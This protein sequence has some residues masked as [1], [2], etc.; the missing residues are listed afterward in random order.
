MGKKKSKKSSNNKGRS[1]SDQKTSSLIEEIGHLVEAKSL[2]ETKQEKT[3]RNLCSK[4]EKLE[5]L[6]TCEIYNSY[7]ESL[8]DDYCEELEEW[9]GEGFSDVVEIKVSHKGGKGIFAKQDIPVNTPI[10]KIS[11]SKMISCNFGEVFE[12]RRDFVEMLM[13][14]PV[15][16]VWFYSI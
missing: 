10:F 16:R 5:S 9:L 12:L 4:I 2:W 11:K 7:Q 6:Q 3:I 1:K 13:R 15:V 8:K 14:D